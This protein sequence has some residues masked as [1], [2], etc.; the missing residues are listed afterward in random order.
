MRHTSV[1]GYTRVSTSTQK[2]EGVSLDDQKQG[3]DRF[4]VS[5]QLQ[6]MEEFSDA[7]SASNEEKGSKRE[8]FK[9]ACSLALKNDWDILVTVKSRA[10][11][12]PFSRPIPTPWRREDWRGLGCAVT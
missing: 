10:N 12:P 6:I 11:A 9:A 2:K 3:L 1:I 4:A 7:V 5:N 8:N